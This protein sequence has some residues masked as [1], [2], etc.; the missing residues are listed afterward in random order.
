MNIQKTMATFAGLIALAFSSVSG[1]HAGG[2]SIVSGTSGGTL[3]SAGTAAT[4]TVVTYNANSATG[5]FGALT[6]T[7]DP[8]ILGPAS[9]GTQNPYAALPRVPAPTYAQPL[10]GSKWISPY[11]NNVPGGGQ[12]QPTTGA[13]STTFRTPAG[14]Y[15][16]STTFSLSSSQTTFSISG[17]TLADDTI[18]NAYLDYGTANQVLLTSTNG[19]PA[20]QKAGTFSGSG[21]YGTG[22]HTLDFIVRDTVTGHPQALDFSGMAVPEP[23]TIA[24]FLIAFLCIGGMMLR[25]RKSGSVTASA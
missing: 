18:V 5:P 3:V 16:Y 11:L 2:A 23:A 20:Y 4:D 19:S 8:V 12:Y 7:S 21:T 15:K 14:Y 25:A 6:T 10:A 1:A 17:S 9:S 13:P 24:A 22:T